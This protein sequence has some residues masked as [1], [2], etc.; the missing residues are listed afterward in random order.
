M[1]I[2]PRLASSVATVLALAISSASLPVRA[3]ADAATVTLAES[4]FVDAKKLMK[5]G[6]F[7]EACPKLVESQRLDPG[8]GTLLL[9]AEC[10]EGEG[11]LA[12]AWSEYREALAIAIKDKRQ[13]RIDRCNQRLAVIEPKLS[14]VTITVP[15]AADVEGLVV[16]LD[17]VALPRAA[18]GGAIPIDPG[19]HTIRATAPGK[20]PR[21]YHVDVA[22]TASNPNVTLEPFV[23]EAKKPDAPP[24][25]TV[26]VDSGKSRRAAGYV[27]VGAGVVAMGVGAIFGFRAIDKRK[28][29]DDHCP[30]DRCDQL[31]VDLNDS[32]KSAA[33][34]AN[35]AIGLGVVAAI[36][37]GVLVLGA[38][39][40]ETRT[41]RITPAIGPTVAGVSFG[42][43]F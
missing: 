14:R 8:G 5:E 6:K 19:K 2:R 40:A 4:L 42:M 35:V 31:G 12:R 23:D 11:K 25:S 20:V 17:G 21:D 29:S 7:A 10:H 34:V 24:P 41:V 30:N 22:E 33:N 15:K 26:V 28:E 37:G 38:P 18:F 1:S 39:K 9:L 16:M 43:S 32:A 3:D 36:V 27:L 13:E